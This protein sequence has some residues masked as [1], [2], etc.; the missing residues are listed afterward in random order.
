M[1]DENSTRTRH[2][3]IT[4][5]PPHEPDPDCIQCDDVQVGSGLIPH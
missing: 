2:H 4:S 3:E 5:Y 1:M